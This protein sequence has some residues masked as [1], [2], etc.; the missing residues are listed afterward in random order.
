MPAIDINE[1]VYDAKPLKGVTLV[2][3]VQS[4]M[5]MMS[6]SDFDFSEPKPVPLDEAYYKERFPGLPDNSYFAL[7]KCS[8][9]M[10]SKQI[11]SEWKKHNKKF[12]VV[13]S[14]KLLLFS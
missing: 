13:R 8:E 6:L 4:E 7:A 1:F 10:K 14:Q 12:A 2:D 3:D 9:G 5:K 11:R